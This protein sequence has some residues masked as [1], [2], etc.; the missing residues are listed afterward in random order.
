MEHSTLELFQNFGVAILLGALMGFERERSGARIAGM[1]TFPLVALFGELSALLSLLGESPWILA[2]GFLVVTALA[3][4][5]NLLQARQRVDPGLTTEIALLIAFG[6]GALVAYGFR[7]LA[8]A[9]T[10]AATSILHFKPHLHAFTRRVTQKDIYAILQFGLVSFIILPVLPNDSFGPFNALNP[11]HIWLMVVLISGISLAGYLL[12][13][14]V[15]GRWGGPAS[16]VLGG[17][18]SSTA[19]TLAF[20]RHTRNHPAFARMAAVVVILASGILMIRVGVEVMIINPGLLRQMLVPIIAILTAGIVVAGI[21]WKRTLETESMVPETKNPAELTGAITFGL[22]YGVV[23]LATSA[24]EHYFGSE[25]VYVVS[26]VS[27]LT[28]VDAIVLSSSRL[29]AS[30]VLAP[31]EARNAILIAVLANLT[32]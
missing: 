30:G 32:F 25:G 5:G 21:I 19:T 2:T 22:I 9:I 7:P 26:L 3:V 27:G 31:V 15:G 6:I 12:M 14:M 8:V 18:V 1:R 28:D 11:H 16:G 20:G 13:K 17:L 23:L 24:G 10:L 29:A 4:T